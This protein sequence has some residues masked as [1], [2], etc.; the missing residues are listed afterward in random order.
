MLG[1]AD[2]YKGLHGDYHRRHA[3]TPAEAPVYKWLGFMT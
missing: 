2:Y 1:K 3:P